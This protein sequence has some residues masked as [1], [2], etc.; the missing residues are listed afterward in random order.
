MAL[1]SKVVKSI[2]GDRV[3]AGRLIQSKPLASLVAK[4][5]LILEGPKWP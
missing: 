2:V 1:G 3:A 5:Y 4:A